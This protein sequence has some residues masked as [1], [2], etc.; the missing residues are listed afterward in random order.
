MSAAKRYFDEKLDGDNSGDVMRSR[1]G[2]PQVSS[3]QLK[4]LLRFGQEC[5]LTAIL[6]PIW[7]LIIFRFLVCDISNLHTSSHLTFFC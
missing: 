4:T 3:K 6:L 7:G 2:L 1:I 5:K